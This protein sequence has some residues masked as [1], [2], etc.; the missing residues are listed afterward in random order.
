MA[1]R[2]RSRHRPERLPIPYIF[3][4]AMKAQP[5]TRAPAKAEPTFST[6]ALAYLEEFSAMLRHPHTLLQT[7]EA[8]R[9]RAQAH[10]SLA[11]VP[12]RRG[13]Y[14]SEHHVASAVSIIAA[15]VQK[16]SSYFFK[17]SISSLRNSAAVAGFVIS[18]RLYQ[19]QVRRQ[20]HLLR[21]AS[22]A[23][24]LR[25]VMSSL[26]ITGR[27]VCARPPMASAHQAS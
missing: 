18:L 14:Q 25:N 9:K 10:E 3:Q 27:A 26:G 24:I 19:S 4:N 5:R 7:L 20:A 15:I 16:A 8:R 1:W 22:G 12:V 11:S 23:P 13:S 17:T 2:R 21:A 6:S